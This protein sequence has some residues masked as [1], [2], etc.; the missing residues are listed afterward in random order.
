MYDSTSPSFGAASQTSFEF[1][2]TIRRNRRQSH[3]TYAFEGGMASPLTLSG[4][5]EYR[6]ETYT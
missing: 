2:K 1:G 6:K 5:A 4:G 3:M